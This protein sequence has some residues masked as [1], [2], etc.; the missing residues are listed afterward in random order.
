MLHVTEVVVMITTGHQS[1][2]AA[3]GLARSGTSPLDDYR[4]L[5]FDHIDPKTKAF[6]VSDCVRRGM[7]R[8]TVLAEIQKCQVLCANCHRIKTFEELRRVG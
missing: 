8:K 7:S 5:D 4:V 2:V 6:N 3:T 1:V